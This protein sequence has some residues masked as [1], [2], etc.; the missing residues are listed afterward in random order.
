MDFDSESSKGE[1]PEDE[2]G[3]DYVISVSPLNYAMEIH[4]P[5]NKSYRDPILDCEIDLDSGLDFEESK[6]ADLRKS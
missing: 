4:S 5:P 2:E 1:S 3:D 6:K